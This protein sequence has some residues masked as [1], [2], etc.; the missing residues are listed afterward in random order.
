M[1]PPFPFQESFH[2]W[3]WFDKAHPIKS[4]YEYILPLFKHILCLLPC[5]ENLT[6]LHIFATY[7]SLFTTYCRVPTLLKK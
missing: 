4:K 5:F 6:S 7:N 3:C 1:Y 2:Q